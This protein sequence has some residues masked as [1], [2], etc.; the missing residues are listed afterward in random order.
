MTQY[1]IG[2]LLQFHLTVTGDGAV[3]PA[4]PPAPRGKT[5]FDTNRISLPP[6]ICYKLSSWIKLWNRVVTMKM[7]VGWMKRASPLR[8]LHRNASGKK[9]FYRTL[10]EAFREVEWS[11]KHLKHKRGA[12]LEPGWELCERRK[13][14]RFVKKLCQ[15]SVLHFTT[16]R[17]LEPALHVCLVIRKNFRS[18]KY[19]ILRL[20]IS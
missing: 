2:T 18:K 11:A 4:I 3:W 6:L 8:F 5:S 12:F 9:F 17:P 1:Q 10:H 19:F 14:E 20:P 7:G 13:R 15:Q 16:L